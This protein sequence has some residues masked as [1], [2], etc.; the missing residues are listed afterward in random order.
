MPYSR[1][2]TKYYWIS[3]QTA[4]GREHQSSGF[5]SWREADRLEKKKRGKKTARPADESICDVLETYLGFIEDDD[6]YERSKSCAK[7]IKSFFGERSVYSLLKSD[8]KKYSKWR[9]RAVATMSK[10]LQLLSKSIDHWNSEHK[11]TDDALPNP[12]RGYIPSAKERLPIYVTEDQC[13]DL[14]NN[15]DP[16]AEG[17]LK[18]LIIVA[19]HTGL[20]PGELLGLTWDRIDLRNKLILFNPDDQKNKSA[21]AV[22]LNDDAYRV[23]RARRFKTKTYLFE[24]LGKRIKSVRKSFNTA[25]R[26]AGIPIVKGSSPKMLRH[27]CATWMVQHGVHL[28]K[29]AKVLRHESITTTEIYTHLTDEDAREAVNTLSRKLSR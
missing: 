13:R 28:K 7:P 16:K 19:V 1:K 23:I 18:D 2:D 20:R 27:T 21:G 24:Y 14:L 9:K 10:E 17:Y 22:P 4:E 26:N 3:Y 25:L 29:V 15:I 11:L 12:L 5:T 6:K 8:I